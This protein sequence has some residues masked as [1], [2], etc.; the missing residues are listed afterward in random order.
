MKKNSKILVTGSG[1]MVGSSLA[2]NLSNLG[3]SNLI[4]LKKMI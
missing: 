2:E 3:Y 1:G 4:L